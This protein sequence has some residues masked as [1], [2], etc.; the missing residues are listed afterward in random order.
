MGLD[1]GGVCGPRRA[2]S[3]EPARRARATVAADRSPAASG[4]RPI[5]LERGAVAPGLN[6]TFCRRLPLSL[7]PGT[8]APL[9]LS[10]V[11]ARPTAAGLALGCLCVSSCCAGLSSGCASRRISR[12]AAAP[13]RSGGKPSSAAAPRAS[14]AAATARWQPSAPATGGAF[15]KRCCLRGCGCAAPCAASPRRRRRDGP[16]APGRGLRLPRGRRQ[17][18]APLRDNAAA[19]RANAS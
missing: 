3:A 7:E 5:N 12:R 17:T 15:C 19:N 14:P 4:D 18:A 6:A 1:C 8:A 16:R 11:L 10:G 9:P 2:R 13:Y